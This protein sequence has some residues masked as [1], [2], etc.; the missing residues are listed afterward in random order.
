[1]S[2]PETERFEVTEDDLYNEFNPNR[3]SWR[4]TKNQATYGIWHHDS[5]DDEDER[6]GFGGGRKKRTKDM[7]VPVS[8]ISGG[9]KDKR[10]N[11]DYKEGEGDGQGEDEPVDE[12][13]TLYARDFILGGQAGSKTGTT[14]GKKV[15]KPK[16]NYP[17]GQRV[18]GMN[19][20]DD[21]FGN[22]EKHT[23]GIGLKLLAKM[24]YEQ[25]KGLGK[26]HQGIATP[27]EAFKRKDT[28]ATIGYHGSERTQR[29]LKDFPQQVDSEEEEDKQ[30]Q[31]QLSQW[32]KAPEAN[33]KLKPKYTYKTADEVI[34]KGGKKK[35][36]K[37]SHLSKVKV[38]DMT[39]KEQRVLSG[40]R[41]IS[42]RHDRPD[43]SSS[44]EEEIIDRKKPK[45]AFEM[46]EL[47]HNLNILVDMAEEEIIENDRKLKYE[48][49]L[50]VNLKYEHEKMEKLCE[51]EAK[52]LKKI[53]EL[54]AIVSSCE[55]RT[56]E[57]CENRISLDE[58]ADIFT[59]LQE[60]YYEEYKIYDLNSL[61]VA[62]V[63]PLV[64]TYF[65]NWEPLKNNKVGLLTI[66]KWKNI[67]EDPNR[68]FTHSQSSMDAYERLMWEIWMP[69]LRA[70]IQKQW[71]V[72]D[73][74]SLIELLENWMP[75]L[76]Q[77][78]LNNIL[79]QQVMPK[80]NEEVENWDPTTDTM[81]I[82]AW[83][84]PWLPLL[85]E[86]LQPLYA[87]IRHKL[88]KALSQWHPSDPSAKMIL[89]PWVK[90][91]KRGH[92]DA[93]LVK[94]IVPKLLQCMQEFVVNP[95]QQQLDPWN[96]V[97]SWHDMLPIT[98]MTTILEKAFFPK[99]LQVLATWLAS[100]PDYNEVTK[101]YQ[102]WKT[103]FSDALKAE[104]IV[105]DKFK[106]ALSY[107]NHAVTGKFQ[108]PGPPPGPPPVPAA[109]Y[110]GPIPP[111][112][113]AS[114]LRTA[115]VTTTSVPS[116]FKDL[117]EKK[118]A[119]NGLIFLP[120]PNR[121]YEA[122]QVYKFGNAVMYLDR[123]VIFVQEMSPIPRWVPMSLNAL[124]TRAT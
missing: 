26:N 99:W 113:T 4:Q 70:V 7:S 16:V 103:M 49:D 101:W 82:H 1:M 58:C 62:M 20:G 118:A 5:D 11:K 21:Q 34:T 35:S 2:S 53:N 64:K 109:T 47:M 66:Q 90:V 77:W 84:H 120:I 75:V 104:P 27:V 123:S 9:Y 17:G 106:L 108:P 112:R 92:L 59:E 41:A 54:F 33:K 72:R 19:P 39:G 29:S 44:E 52:Q 46:P 73:S 42:S 94:N 86:R 95:H 107:M 48:R 105:K 14:Y 65:D 57:E 91:F 89:T 119:E 37:Q 100:N 60:Q 117:V 97:M 24:G 85:G 74:D 56:K 116:S 114:P 69:F 61:A 18:V 78:I 6:P 10:D 80:L 43:E 38:I 45:K 40:Y 30:F 111:E 81:P 87:S 3:P 68:R 13:K 23:S 63:F 31:Q 67:L 102:G 12:N 55:A 50:V 93:F 79:E 15:K 32:K 22:W 88:S 8:F 124:V 51:E 25:G 115:G 122:K 96:W 110:L 121:T 76:P 28:K 36:V 83:L 71:S 98:S